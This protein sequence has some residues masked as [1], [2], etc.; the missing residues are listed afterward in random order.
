MT[1][2]P[3]WAAKTGRR[4]GYGA[5]HRAIGNTTPANAVVIDAVREILP[6]VKHHGVRSC[7]NVFISHRRHSSSGGQLIGGLDTPGRPTTTRAEHD[8]GKTTPTS[9]RGGSTNETIPARSLGGAATSHHS[10][11]EEDHRGPFADRLLPRVGAVAQP[12]LEGLTWTTTRAWSTARRA[13]P[14]SGRRTTA[15]L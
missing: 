6:T 3:C 13:T 14:R 2:T 10:S 9:H 11:Q 5:G 8:E 1:E 7:T 4:A 15:R 12:V